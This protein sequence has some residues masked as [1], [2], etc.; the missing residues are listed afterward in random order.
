MGRTHLV[1][2]AANCSIAEHVELLLR[3][4]HEHVDTG[5][6]IG[7]LIAYVIHKY[8]NETEKHCSSRRQT[9]KERREFRM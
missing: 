8:L 6:H 4:A 2:V 7:R 5:F 3:L 1:D 9:R